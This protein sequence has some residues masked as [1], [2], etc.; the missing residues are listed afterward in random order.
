MLMEFGIPFN[1][2]SSISNESLSETPFPSTNF[3]YFCKSLELIVA[4][5]CKSLNR[6]ELLQLITAL[7]NSIIRDQFT[8]CA[9]DSIQNI[10]HSLFTIYLVR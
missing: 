3:I 1:E 5:Y 6:G 8:C 2:S 9:I 10:L 4:D 7:Y